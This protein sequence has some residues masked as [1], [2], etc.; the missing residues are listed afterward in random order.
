[1]HM[2]RFSTVFFFFC[3]LT[4]LNRWKKRGISLVPTLHGIG[5]EFAP[6]NQA[7]ALVH[8]Y[9][10]GSVL[11]SHGGVEMGQV[12]IDYNELSYHDGS[13]LN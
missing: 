8:V 12:R 6:L 13:F 2:I 5:I 7:G 11:L 10:D 9:T 3:K 4:R 1:M